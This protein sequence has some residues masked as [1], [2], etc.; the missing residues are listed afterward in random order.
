[1]TNDLPDLSAHTQTT[2]QRYDH[3]TQVRE[4]RW[5]FTGMRSLRA[6]WPDGT[7]HIAFITHDNSDSR[8]TSVGAHDVVEIEVGSDD[9][10]A[11]DIRIESKD[12]TPMTINL[13]GV[14]LDD[15]LEAVAKAVA[16]KQPITEDSEA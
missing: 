16:E 7:H 6:A 3:G 8:Q 14:T 1:M 4:S 13:F 5:T 10:L 15:L 2:F 11:L 9:S 12:G